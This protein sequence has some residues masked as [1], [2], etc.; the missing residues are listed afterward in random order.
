MPHEL[1]PASS[2]PPSDI[3]DSTL[4]GW[5]DALGRVLADQRREWDRDR[6]L[7]I[8]EVR[9]E[10]AALT[11]RVHELVAE[12]LATV[13]DGERGPVGE[14]GLQGPAGEPGER[15]EPGGQGGNGPPGVDGPPGPP[16]APGERGEKGDAGEVGP[17]GE[18]G[19]A[20]EPGEAGPPGVEPHAPDDVAVLI[21]RAVALL[22]E[23]PAIVAAAAPA[24]VVNVTVPAPVRSVER[25]RVTKHDDKGR[26]LEIE[27]DVA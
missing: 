20:G 16:G 12:R 22:A 27:R 8:A 2:A 11:L 10:V 26:I 4:D 24:P 23:A 5:T 9:A 6:A 7:A 15:G 21:G 13:K 18:P 14:Q 17:R 25:T 3:A 1:L 19:P